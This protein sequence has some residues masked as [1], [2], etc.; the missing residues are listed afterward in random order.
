MS[1]TLN[2]D[3][4]APGSASSSSLAVPVESE[5]GGMI[6]EDLSGDSASP[7]RKM[8]E[9]KDKSPSRSV[10]KNWSSNSRPP[11][12][13]WSDDEEATLLKKRSNKQFVPYLNGTINEQYVGEHVDRQKF[14]S[15]DGTVKQEVVPEA[16]VTERQ[17]RIVELDAKSH[18]AARSKVSCLDA[19]V[20]EKSIGNWGDQMQELAK[21]GEEVLTTLNCVGFMNAP[22]CY[23]DLQGECKLFRLAERS[24]TPKS[25]TTVCGS[26]PMRRSLLMKP[27]TCIPNIL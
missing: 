10:S 25:S 6:S 15:K 23:K 2:D 24:Q 8:S 21:M 14:V 27:V 12:N 17:R 4:L 22:Q 26:M 11:L 9:D 13:D 20:L 3:L 1:Q 7:Y 16:I 5:S 19:G 18:K